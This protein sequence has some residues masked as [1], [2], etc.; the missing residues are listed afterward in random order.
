[1]LRTEG[2]AVIINNSGTYN[3]PRSNGGGYNS[4][5]KEPVAELNLPM[6]AHGRMER[7]IRNKVP[8]E[9]EV[10]ILNKFFASPKIFNV[11]GEIPGT[12]KLLKNEVVLLGAHIDS[13]HGGTGAADNAS[14]C[15]VM[16][17]ALRILKSLNVAPRRTIRVALWGGEEQGLN[18]S[19]G[20]VEKYLVDPKTKA[21]KPDFDKFCVYFNMD[22]GSGRYRGVYLQQNEMARPIFEELLKP[23][24]SLG[25]TTIAIRNTG[26]TDHQSFDRVGLPGFQF[27]QDEIEYGRTYHTV[28]DTYER[29]VLS[30]LRINAIITASLA[31]H[32]AMRNDKF[33]GKP[34]MNFPERSPYGM[35]P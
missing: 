15:V 25:C 5:E 6:E 34:V 1:M 27:I 2:A 14:G 12:D 33:P 8:V 20:Y 30:D 18:G 24:E 28:M 10:E 9:M 26:G 4:G 35:I 17:E 16:M 22:N 31:Y 11:I 7:L 32:A 29:L 3:I 21:K 13:W 23:F 19:R